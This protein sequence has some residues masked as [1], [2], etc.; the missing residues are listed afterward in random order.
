MMALA[1]ILSPLFVGSSFAVFWALN[2]ILICLALLS[3][4]L[5]RLRLPL[6]NTWFSPLGLAFAL[7]LV[8]LLWMA[9]QIVPGVPH[10]IAHPAWDELTAA[11]ATISIDPAATLRAILWWLA[12]AI[13]FVASAQGHRSRRVENN[14]L[15]MG[16][17]GVGVAIFGL[18][19][20]YFGWQSIGLLPKTDYGDWL[21]GTFNNRNAVASFFSICLCAVSSLGLKKYKEM[22]AE[23]N[24]KSSFSAVF[25]AATSA[26]SYYLAL[27]LVILA[28]V[29]LTGSRAGT[30]SAALAPTLVWAI[31]KRRFSIRSW[32]LPV[33]IL[34][35]GIV[36]AVT[37]N[38]LLERAQGGAASSLSR[39]PLLQES[40]QAIWARPLLGHGGGAY[41]TIE[42]LFHSDG[43]ATN[44]VYTHA[45]NSYT[46]AAADLGVPFTVIWVS[47]FIWLCVLL[48]RRMRRDHHFKPASAAFF[49][50]I[51]LEAL[52]AL[53]DFS[54]H[55]QAVAIY[56]ACLLGL[57][58]GENSTSNRSRDK[59]ESS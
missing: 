53:V 55:T 21:T 33:V 14:L 11:A 2:G 47:G 12:M 4:L 22:K 20:A 25:L 31:S 15:L 51:T 48:W 16:A 3:L 23:T 34:G 6:E 44:A 27:M 7:F 24:R 56:L 38:A 46:E 32:R 59:A 40:L 43:V 8:P 26:Q 57:T 9:V 18:A 10:G 42:P 52:H 30:V 37:T 29:L 5:E 35:S 58:I 19:N 41:Q 1:L 13:V 49:A 28:A 54:L 45:H 17:V 39:L 36:I 50:A